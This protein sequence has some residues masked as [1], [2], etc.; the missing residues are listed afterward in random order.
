MK[1]PTHE[2]E[3]ADGKQKCI[4]PWII[5]ASRATD[6]PA[7]FSD[8][9]IDKIRKGYV[10]WVNP[11]N[12]KKPQYVSFSNT[13]VVVFWSKNPRPLIPYLRE[14]DEKK[15]QYYFQFTL[16]DYEL[17]GFE[18]RVPPLEERVETFQMLSELIGKDKVIWRFDPLLI[19]DR[20]HPDVLLEKIET[21]GEKLHGL[22][23]KLVFS[24]ADISRYKK[25]QNNLKSQG[26][27]YKEFSVDTMDYVAEKISDLTQSWGLT[28]ATCGESRVLSKYGIIKNKCIDDELIL[29]ITHSKTRNKEFEKFLG[30]NPQRDIFKQGGASD[31]TGKNLKDKG[32]RKDCG[33][34]YSKD[35]G[36]YNT[37]S[38]LCVY[39]YA[40]NSS[41]AVQNNMNQIRV[42]NEA[43][44]P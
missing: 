44:L 24:F 43:L 40:N 3:T 32:Q 36:S 15:I 34:I 5:S 29:K 42:D 20:T 39:C 4:A 14:L 30:F 31:D 12:R 38:H 13:Q 16:N 10:K 37:C 23:K 25:V 35:I 6:L 17:E 27:H 1:W 21:T 2:I 26:I 9:F 41:R 11:F 19:T 18:P 7:F 8:W 28:A 33:C 22:T